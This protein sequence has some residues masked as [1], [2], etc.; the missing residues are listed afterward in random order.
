MSDP[1]EFTPKTEQEIK[2]EGLLLAG[3]CDFEVT[4]SKAHTSASS[5][6]RSIKMS[7]NV[8]DVQGK[9]AWLDVYLTPAYMKLLAHACDV[10]GLMDKY[11]AGKVMAEDF[12]GKSGKLIIRK[13]VDQ[14]GNPQ[15]KV[16][17]FVKRDLADSKEIP[18]GYVKPK[19]TEEPVDPFN[20]EIPF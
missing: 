1:F 7:M 4:S 16:V 13:D 2:E 11:E 18:I 3:T 5:G 17:D 6:K 20:D 10:C 8:Y 12:E 14:N 19:K 15:N 9:M